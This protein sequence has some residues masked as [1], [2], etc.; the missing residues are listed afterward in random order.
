MSQPTTI[1]L[2]PTV[3]LTLRALR[4][5]DLIRRLGQAATW[6]LLAVVLAAA[7]LAAVDS[8]GRRESGT[9]TRL[10]QPEVIV[11]MPTPSPSTVPA[12]STVEPVPAPA[13]S[14]GR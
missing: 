6:A 2:R 3:S 7:M 10:A 9:P 13:P 12:T 5:D 1:Q 8:A 14:Y 4:A 11:R